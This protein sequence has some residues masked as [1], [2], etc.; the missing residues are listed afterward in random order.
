[1]D[2][3]HDKEKPKAWVIC[4]NDYPHSVVYGSESEAEKKRKKF[5]KSSHKDRGNSMNFWHKHEV[6]F[7]LE[8]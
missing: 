1:M 7:Y 6:D 4:N 5:E 2:M 8:G 3:T